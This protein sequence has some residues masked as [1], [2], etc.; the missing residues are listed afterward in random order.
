MGPT[1]PGLQ[2]VLA[3]IVLQLGLPE[4]DGEIIHREAEMNGEENALCSVWPQGKCGSFV[5]NELHSQQ[6]VGNTLVSKNNFKFVS[7][8][9]GDGLELAPI[10]VC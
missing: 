10:L 5:R 7:P 2:Q 3:S 4:G 9:S 1:I 8:L 6:P